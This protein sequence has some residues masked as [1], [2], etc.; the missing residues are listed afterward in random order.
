[1]TSTEAKDKKA[2]TDLLNFLRTQGR[3]AAEK[4][5]GRLTLLEQDRKTL[6]IGRGTQLETRIARDTKN[7]LALDA[8][9][10]N[11]HINPVEPPGHSRFDVLW[12]AILRRTETALF[13]ELQT[14]LEILPQEAAGQPEDPKATVLNSE[15]ITQAVRRLAIDIRDSMQSMPIHNPTEQGT[16]ALHNFLG[17]RKVAKALSMAGPNATVPHLQFIHKNRHLLEE[18]AK[19][20]PNAVILWYK[21]HNPPHSYDAGDKNTLIKQA[22][23]QF[24]SSCYG[25]SKYSEDLRNQNK[26][27]PG[28]AP[29]EKL[30]WQAFRSLDTQVLK[31]HNP[32][33]PYRDTVQHYVHLTDFT[34]LLDSPPP[35]WVQAF[36]LNHPY[37]LQE[38]VPIQLVRAFTEQARRT[39]GTQK[40]QTLQ[41]ELHTLARL[42]RRYC[43]NPSKQHKLSPMAALLDHTPDYNP[44][45]WATLTALIPVGAKQAPSSPKTTPKNFNNDF[46]RYIASAPHTV[47]TR[48]LTS[49]TL[50]VHGTPSRSIAVYQEPA[51]PPL[52]TLKREEDRTISYHRDRF[53]YSWPDRDQLELPEPYTDHNTRPRDP[54]QRLSLTRK[55]NNL[56]TEQI[57]DYLN[58]HWKQAGPFPNTARPS[59][60][61]LASN[62][63][64]HTAIT[65]PI[66]AEQP[67]TAHII[68]SQVIDGITDLLDQEIW[69]RTQAIAGKVK[70]DQYNAVMTLGQHYT[71]LKESNPGAFTWALINMGIQAESILHPGQI[72][73]MA[74][75]SLLEAGLEPAHWKFAA[76][77]PID[78]MQKIVASHTTDASI[79]ILNATA[80]AQA[81]PTA[82]I[83][84]K[85]AN[86]VNQSH[87]FHPIG[88]RPF[89]ERNKQQLESHLNKL[90]MSTM[91]FLICRKSLSP[92]IKASEE[93]Q[94]QLCDTLAS[95][96]DYVNHLTDNG[97]TL[98]STTWGGLL[99]ASDKWH[100]EENLRYQQDTWDQ[101][102]NTL[103][104]AYMAWNSAL[105]EF[106][107]DGYTITPLTDEKQLHFEALHM[108]HCVHSYGN[109]CAS[110]SSR[111]FSISKQGK[112]LATSEIR[113]TRN[114][115]TPLQTR[116]KD[117]HKPPNALI[118]LMAQVAQD[119]QQA[120]KLTPHKGKKYIL[121]T[122]QPDPPIPQ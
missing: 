3:S 97:V 34:I 100:Q 64:L 41:T 90:N 114:I 36:L 71:A 121:I 72:I 122:D 75:S 18:L 65:S 112:P 74:K 46:H 20:E 57:H 1:M 118:T 63:Y 6:V 62:L 44:P 67:I 31:Q 68:E 79:I 120:E 21:I 101:R 103:G 51:E 50:H 49:E 2:L 88:P 38:D 45:T 84:E 83:A 116:T 42:Y 73:A 14:H 95:V 98:R 29:L 7:R 52:I 55:M 25:H 27:T 107:K 109:Q 77:L 76:T 61:K 54:L 13:L 48:L 104:G 37:Y 108:N 4:R 17:T 70:V 56:N 11:L 5:L 8:N 102:L 12:R 111:I 33:T 117:N 43:A 10:Y 87:F 35:P 15:E 66:Y 19:E 59:H 22:R 53:F 110:G 91:V 40:Q 96:R 26:A 106:H 99:K 78:V 30:L 24:I 39:T 93:N 119:Y 94:L 86:T 9:A 85:L 80:K 23:S 115:W 58:Q 81:A 92:E 89:I 105:G 32:N 113:K 28:A 82:T 47:E 69:Q 16:L 60:A